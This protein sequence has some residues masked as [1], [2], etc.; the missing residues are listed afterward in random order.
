MGLD[1]KKRRSGRFVFVRSCLTMRLLNEVAQLS[2]RGPRGRT[3][4]KLE[5][6]LAVT[7]RP[8]AA[9][10]HLKGLE[11]LYQVSPD[12]PTALVGDPGR[13]RQIITNLIGNAIKFT[14]QGEVTLHV[15]TESRTEG[16]AVLH[17]S[18]SDTG[19]GVSPEKQEAIFKPFIQ[20]DGSITRTY[21]GTGLGLA[22]S[23]GLVALLG[24]RIWL[25]S[26]S[27]K[28]STFHFTARFGLQKA[29]APEMDPRE[30][31]SLQGMPVLVVDDNAVNRR[32][33]DAMLKHWLMTPTLTEGGQAGLA[34]MREHKK[35]GKAF[36][37]VL[38]DAQMPDMDGFALAEEIKKDPELAGATLMM[39]TS[40][41]RPGDGARC[42][43]LGIAAYMVKPI[44]QSELLE[45]ILA[46]LDKPSRKADRP[47]VITRHSLR[48]TR[49]KLHILLAEDNL[50][51]QKL[52]VR[53]IE[54]R[55]HTLVV[56]SNGR[57]ALAALES[58]SFDVVLMDVQM[59]EMNGFEATAAIRD[60]EKE[61]GKHLPIIAMTANA[62]VG[63]RERCL[64]AGM[65]GYISKPIRIE[66]L[67]EVIESLGSTA[68]AAKPGMSHR[69]AS[70]SVLD[71]AAALARVEGDKDTLVEMTN[72]FLEEKPKLLAAVREAVSR[73]DAK[74][75]E[76]AAHALKGSVGNFSAEGAF[77]A[78][79]NLEI[80]GRQGDLSG[81]RE[82]YEL[83]HVQIERLQPALEALIMDVVGRRS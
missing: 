42:R 62:M 30:T 61:T 29:P 1:D 11:L 39:L 36:P 73:R 49:E 15:E 67:F 20:A 80:M 63:D 64:A 35:A 83:L 40:S 16:V 12:V 23:T 48:E 26:E 69:D 17:F 10:A 28:G 8:L 31:I 53:L 4:F 18:V 60:R 56:A 21:G 33:L 22:I 5:D 70:M 54:K 32:I 7:I 27:G 24:G 79:L 50:V 71:S 45:A 14:E 76:Y 46:A 41:G 77:Q 44:R 55:G 37:L 75:L 34:A 66:E 82:A 3:E 47:H 6:S 19:I 51:N 65:D 57:E 58:E 78:A 81:A 38:L 2:L 68:V 52:A 9:R 13:L 43:E 59:P 74:A 25:E 72:L